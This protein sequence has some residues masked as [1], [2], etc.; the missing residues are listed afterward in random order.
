VIG[1]LLGCLLGLP[2]RVYRRVLS[3]L[4]PPT[5]RFVPTCSS[6]AIEALATWGPLRGGWLVLR[7]LARCHPYCEPGEDPVP[8]RA[9]RG[10][11]SR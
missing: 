3:P 6:Y 10:A 4:K 5:C 7:R 9:Q 1:R 2:I 11:S 8:P